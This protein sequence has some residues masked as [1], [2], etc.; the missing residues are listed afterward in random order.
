MREGSSERLGLANEIQT[1]KSYC[2]A[3]GTVFNILG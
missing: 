1:T 2:I 3:Q